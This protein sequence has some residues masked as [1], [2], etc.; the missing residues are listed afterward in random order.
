MHATTGWRAIYVKLTAVKVKLFTA[1]RPNNYDFY[2]N[3]KRQMYTVQLTACQFVLFL[4]FTFVELSANQNNNTIN[5]CQQFQLT[6]VLAGLKMWMRLFCCFSFH[7]IYACIVRARVSE[8]CVCVCVT[9]R[10]PTRI[11]AHIQNHSISH[12]TSKF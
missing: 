11:I 1:H 12:C 2:R 9:H 3:R 10:V 4:S 5:T 8:T 6:L 7:F